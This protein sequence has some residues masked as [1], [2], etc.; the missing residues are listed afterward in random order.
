[1][2]ADIQRLRGAII[3]DFPPKVNLSKVELCT[4]K[5]GE[6]P[7][8]FVEPIIKTFQRHT[9]LNPEA[10]EHRNLLISILVINF[11]P[12]QKKKK[13]FK[14]VCSSGLVNLEAL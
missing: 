2:E 14:R 4:Q 6:N 9:A 13:K 10:P 11:L 12:D 3:Q 7:K 8:A 1:M 5:E